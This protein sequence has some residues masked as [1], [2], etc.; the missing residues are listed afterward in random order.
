M[1]NKHFT[2]RKDSQYQ[3]KSNLSL[4]NFLVASSENLS[5][6]WTAR[7]AIM[8]YMHNGLGAVFS[9]TAALNQLTMK[10]RA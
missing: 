6:L 3:L 7:T 9:H 4:I 8:K 1:K 5:S 10:Y 2:P